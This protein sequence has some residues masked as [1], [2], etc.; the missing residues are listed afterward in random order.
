MHGA[1]AAIVPPMY[2]S[3]TSLY[4]P[5]LQDLGLHSH[6]HPTDQLLHLGLAEVGHADG[7]HLHT[8][9]RVGMCSVEGVQVTRGGGGARNSM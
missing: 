2:R 8:S 3:C 7:A 1:L 4:P 6:R 9:E 5:H